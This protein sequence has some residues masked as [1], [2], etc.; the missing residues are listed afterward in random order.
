MRKD[1]VGFFWDD[2]PV[3]KER[4]EVVKRQPPEPTWL[5]PDYLPYL[6][7]AQALDVPLMTYSELIDACVNG[8]AQ[9]TDVESYPNY[10]CCV[11]TDLATKKSVFFEMEEDGILHIGT[12][13]GITTEEALQK[14]LWILQ[15]FTTAG[16]NSHSY[17]NTILQ[18]VGAGRG[19]AVLWRAT[20]MIIQENWRGYDV[21]KQFKCKPVKMDSVDMIEVAPLRASLKIYGGR[22]HC[23]KMQDLP[24]QPGTLLSPMQKL[25]VRYYCFNDL[26]NTVDMYDL[27]KPQLELRATMSEEIQTDLRS[28][29][30]AQ[31]AEAVIAHEIRLRTGIKRIGKPEIP[32]GTAYS[33]NV[34]SY[35]HFQTPLLQGVLD[36]VRRA[37]FVVGEN[38]SVGLPKEL[39]D[40]KIQIGNSI[41]RMGIGGLHSTEKRQAALADEH[42]ILVDR[43]VT[44][45]Y[46]MMILNQGLYPKHIGPVFLEVFRN[47][48]MR[49]IQAKRDG[50][51]IVAD[52]LKITINGSFGKFG[53]KYSILYS[54]DLLFQTTVSGQLNLFMLIEALELNGIAVVSANTDG[55]VIRCPKVKQE[56]LAEIIKWWENV[57][58]LQTEDSPYRA[59]Y[60]RDVNNYIAIGT[61]GKVKTKGAYANPWSQTKN[62][63]M[64]L[65]K[66]PTN[67]ICIEAVEKLLTTGVPVRQT[68]LED[69]DITKFVSVRTVK[70]GAVKV[71]EALQPPNHSSQEELIQLAGGQYSEGLDYGHKP[72]SGWLFPGDHAMYPDTTPRHASTDQAYAR[73]HAY[74]SKPTKTEYLG[75]SIRWYY[76]K[77]VTGELIYATSGNKVPKSDGAMPLMELPDVFP[78]NIDYDW[79]IDEAERILSDIGYS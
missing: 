75:K 70:G 7:Q 62:M 32:P 54:P 6:E 4:K 59:L 33:Y 41:Y 14:F 5:S 76:G 18:L 13:E 73:A 44:S 69:R 2:T 58:N 50:N 26:T 35:M 52:S 9:A 66:N 77:G 60:S 30:D 10:F 39:A 28:K 15:S 23:K 17:D 34:P 67:T 37:S 57:T 1:A 16:F 55:I 78:D 56:L 64:R 38:G 74:F 36:T 71:W 51:S 63:S 48:V 3:E 31:I 79:Y 49:R 65:H 53:S 21:L 43:D 12:A 29:S 8:R 45:Y 61:D 20:E 40:L 47:I 27:L 22:M 68:I 72:Y 42:F 11:F 19:P 24:F 25:I 46:P